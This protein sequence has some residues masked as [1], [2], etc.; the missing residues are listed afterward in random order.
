VFRALRVIGT[1]SDKRIRKVRT[2]EESTVV[3]TADYQGVAST[4][5]KF[6]ME[7]IVNAAGDLMRYTAEKKF[8]G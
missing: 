1:L 7:M 6:S 2:G 8:F 4:T 5:G 3:M